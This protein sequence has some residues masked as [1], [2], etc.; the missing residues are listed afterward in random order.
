MSAEIKLNMVDLP[1]GLRAVIREG[2]TVI[3]KNGG[4]DSLQVR[5]YRRLRGEQIPKIV[6][7]LEKRVVQRP[8][9]VLAKSKKQ[10][11]PIGVLVGKLSV[12]TEKEFAKYDR[13]ILS[14]FEGKE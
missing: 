12:P 7:K 2:Q 14:M 11:R 10:L 8:V 4:K 3:I 1:E 9:G 6:E 13:E 5:A